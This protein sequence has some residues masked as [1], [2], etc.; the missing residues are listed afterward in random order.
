[1]KSTAVRLACPPCFAYKQHCFQRSCGKSAKYRQQEPPGDETISELTALAA[2]T[3]ITKAGGDNKAKV[4][5]DLLARQHTGH[6][7][8]KRH[9]ESSFCVRQLVGVSAR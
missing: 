9:Q 4:I 6:D 7:V 5:T 1:M 2:V 3:Q 8:V